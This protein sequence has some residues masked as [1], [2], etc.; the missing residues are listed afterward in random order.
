MIQI[1]VPEPVA[2]AAVG[3]F[4]YPEGLVTCRDTMSG[5]SP[6]AIN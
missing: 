3:T 4:L 1:Y 5:L 2:R 6:S